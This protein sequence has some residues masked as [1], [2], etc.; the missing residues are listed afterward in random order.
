MRMR[1]ITPLVLS[2][3][4]TPLMAS[5]APILPGLWEIS[6]SN[7][8]VD[9]QQM[10]AMDVMIEKLK[11]LPPEQRQMM[12]QMLAKQGVRL[13]DKGVQIC[14]SEAQVKS[15]E[16]PLQEQ[17]G[18]KQQV[19][20]RSDKLWKFSFDCPQAKGQGETKFI[21]DK[22]FTN[23]VTSTFNNQGKQQSGTMQTNASWV[24]ADC[25]TLKPQ[26]SN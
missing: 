10:P 13:G 23:T 21:N 26:Q 12:E 22:Q 11:T 25:G 2:L 14:L 16:L 1:F 5:A 3:G 6:T 20:E 24:G 17:S 9:G 8:A 4:F 15:D 7:M 19:T 18:C